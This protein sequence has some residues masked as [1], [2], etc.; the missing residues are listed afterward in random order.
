ME[1]EGDEE[2]E[3]RRARIRHQDDIEYSDDDQRQSGD[4]YSSD[5]SRFDSEDELY[6]SGVEE[7]FKKKPQNNGIRK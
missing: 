2:F 5:D 3:K 6:S 1:G 4:Q 7:K